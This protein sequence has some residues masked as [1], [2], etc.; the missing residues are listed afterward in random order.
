MEKN[1]INL[2]QLPAL[3]LPEEIVE[4]LLTNDK[5]RVER[6]ISSGQT[7]AIYDQEE[8]ELVF[9]L[10]GEAKIKFIEKGEIHLREGDTLNIKAHE[11]HQ[12]T[13]TSESPP[14]IWLCVF[15]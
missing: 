8:N 15:Y 2:Y 6:I 1:K 5:I 9:L 13:F 11:R 10:A 7:S 4:V 14:C 3:S 12:V